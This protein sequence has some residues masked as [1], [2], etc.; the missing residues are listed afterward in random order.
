MY[1]SLSL[2]AAANNV[3]SREIH[4]GMYAT[5]EW[6]FC[7]WKREWKFPSIISFHWGSQFVSCCLPEGIL[8]LGTTFYRAWCVVA[9]GGNGKVS[10]YDVHGWLGVHPMC[11]SSAKLHH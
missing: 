8:T 3:K 5:M 1:I 4:N 9:E 10:L 6:N 11:L 7:L 2:I